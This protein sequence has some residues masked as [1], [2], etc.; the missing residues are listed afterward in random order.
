MSTSKEGTCNLS[1]LLGIQ[2]SLTLITRA[3]SIHWQLLLWW[4]RFFLWD[5]AHQKYHMSA[6]RAAFFVSLDIAPSPPWFGP[7]CCDCPF[8]NLLLCYPQ[9]LGRSSPPQQFV[10]APLVLGQTLQLL[11]QWGEVYWSNI[12]GRS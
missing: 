6:S 9:R 10:R 2:F 8:Q 12:T 4:K 11:E 5:L 3:A 1:S 7:L